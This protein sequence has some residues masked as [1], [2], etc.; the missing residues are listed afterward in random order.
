MSKVA[1]FW[2]Y[3]PKFFRYPQNFLPPKNFSASPNFFYPFRPENSFFTLYR[4]EKNFFRPK[5]FFLDLKNFYRLFRPKIFSNRLNSLQNIFLTFKVM[6][7]TIFSILAFIAINCPTYY[8]LTRL[9]NIL[10]K[11][12][13]R[14]KLLRIQ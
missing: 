12:F 3:F 5:N 8:Q 14:P 10:R 1:F 7:K 6:R 9:G 13:K 2:P 4:P 11:N